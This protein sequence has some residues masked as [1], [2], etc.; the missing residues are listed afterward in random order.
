MNNNLKKGQRDYSLYLYEKTE[1]E[2][3]YFA[4]RV[5]MWLFTYYGAGQR[6][7]WRKR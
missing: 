3:Y 1:R 6:A 4:A 7:V 5:L 2:D